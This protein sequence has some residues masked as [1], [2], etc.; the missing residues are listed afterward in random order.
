MERW[1]RDTHKLIFLFYFLFENMPSPY[2][3]DSHCPLNPTLNN[4]RLPF[5]SV[6]SCWF[7]TNLWE[8]VVKLCFKKILMIFFCILEKFRVVCFLLNALLTSVSYIDFVHY[9]HF[10]T[11]FIFKW[12]CINC[13]AYRFTH[14]LYIMLFYF[15]DKW[16][17]ITILHFAKCTCRKLRIEDKNRVSEIY[18][19]WSRRGLIKCKSSMFAFRDVCIYFSKK[20][21]SHNYALLIYLYKELTRHLH[22]NVEWSES[23]VPAN[24]L[25][26]MPTFF[27]SIL[28]HLNYL[29]ADWVLLY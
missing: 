16:L 3:W 23:A 9:V 17:S 5:G 1:P 8:D 14:I 10:K 13:M 12:I 28:P 7:R 27:N 22:V 25:S 4:W 18:N 26:Y 19:S 11:Q 29:N 2:I 24:F 15:L 6:V 20:T 21:W